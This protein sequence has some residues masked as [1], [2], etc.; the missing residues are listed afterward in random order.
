M[1]STT[2]LLLIALLVIG[3]CFGLYKLLN[4]GESQATSKQVIRLGIMPSIDHLP[5][6]IA[7]HLGIYDSLGLDLELVRFFSPMERDVALQTQ[8]VDG[9]VT[10]YT[11]AMIQQSKGLALHMPIAL[12]GLF[13]LIT[14]E[15]VDSLGALAGKR[16]ALSSN[17]VIE[18]ATDLVTSGLSIE[19][20]E[21]QK[22][23]IRL[24][25]LRKGEVDAAVLPQPF[26]QMAMN[27]G[28]QHVSQ[29][30][31]TGSGAVRITGLALS[32][33]IVKANTDLLGKLTEGYNRA[34]A[35][36]NEHDAKDWVDIAAKELGVEPAVVASMT[37]D[38]F[39]EAS[40][41]SV[42]ELTRVAEWLKAKELVPASYDPM[43]LLSPAQ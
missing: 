41:P 13:Y 10:D 6:A 4:R 29:V 23:P 26:A 35:Y 2:R 34:V 27:S 30:L 19:K 37:F 39:I 3:A 8:Q 33:E 31:G 32:D 1:K 17:T 9:A 20:I 15:Q 11:T 36:L 25:M 18:Y 14:T 43:R 21:V 7:E 38:S 24:E 28:L 42:Q 12:D 16:F 22:L 5:I 40:S